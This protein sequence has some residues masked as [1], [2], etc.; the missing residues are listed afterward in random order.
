MLLSTTMLASAYAQNDSVASSD[1]INTV[2]VTGSYI[3]RGVDTPSPVTIMT[4][5][6]LD[7]TPRT[8]LGE[9]FHLDPAFSGSEVFTS[10]GTGLGSSG[11]ASVNLRG[12]GPRATLV[13][14]NGR[15]SV[16]NS[17]PTRDG[18][19]TFDINSLIPE[20]AIQRVEILKDGASAIYGSDAIAGV[21]NFITRDDFEGME[22]KANWS[23][24]DTAGQD[25]RLI[26]GIFGTGNDRSH[27]IVAVE[28]LDRDA[29][30]FVDFPDVYDWSVANGAYSNNLNPGSFR[31]IPGQTYNATVPAGPGAANRLVRDPLCGDSRLGPPERAGNPGFL[32]NSANNNQV[33]LVL[34][35]LGRGAISASKRVNAYA[36][37]T[38]EVS[39]LL[40]LGLEAGFSHLRLARAGG[41]GYA[42]PELLVPAS[43][44]GNTFG[45]DVMYRGSIFGPAIGNGNEQIAQVRNET[46]RL[47]FLADGQISEMGNWRWS[48]NFTWSR[49]ESLAQHPDTVVDRMAAA[50][51]GFGGANCDPTTGTAGVG[52]CSYFNPFA[53]Q[54]LASPGDPLYNDP[55]LVNYIRDTAYSISSSYMITYSAV[56]HGNLFDLPGG[57]AG[58]A[59]GYDYR[60]EQM[61]NDWDALTQGGGFAFASRSI[62]FNKSRDSNAAFFELSIPPI[63]HL[64]I[65]VAGRYE[66][67]GN[68]VNKF[69]PKGSLLWTPLDNLFVRA[70]AGKSFRAPD[71]LQSFGTN[72]GVTDSID[73]PGFVTNSVRAVTSPNPGLKPEQATS[74][75]A[76]V[77]WDIANNLTASLD[78]WRINFSDLT[79]QQDPNTVVAEYA[80]TGAHAN[81]LIFDGSGQLIQLNLVFDNFSSIH[82]RGFDFSLAWN[83]DI[84]SIGNISLSAR[85]SWTTKYTY[86]VRS[87][88]PV[89]DGLGHVNNNVTV[90]FPM[91]KLKANFVAGWQNDGH[92]AQATLRYISGM[93]NDRVAVDSPLQT[94]AAYYQL[95]LLYSYTFEI[96]G[97]PLTLRASVNNV[98]DERPPLLNGVQPAIPGVYDIRGRVFSLGLSKAF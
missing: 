67:Y 18:V 26:S 46:W 83:K 39:N 52:D 43:N 13:L 12:L 91:P 79:G 45:G 19:V 4:Q 95:D 27:I 32:G 64:E 25:E 11:S 89:V 50:L 66:D 92:Y 60:K 55:D 87:D 84:G 40:N 85:G 7:N 93:L 94:K 35:N 70:T 30:N 65:D 8:S 44:P 5:Q 63:E 3:P 16:Y 23:R 24:T 14:L 28:Y 47:A 88:L 2:T 56:V 48:S 51:Q 33:C 1:T 72:A 29:L 15:R 17:E 73:V 42:E 90:V 53:S 80:A 76:G 98:W 6:D 20:I 82:T 81:Q 75:T 38:Y 21:V 86:Q 41:Y 49:N 37:A 9:F 31:L 61:R 10:F 71:L 62:P 59:I 68:G 96:A 78:W 36:K 69:V 97:G 57:A 22:M 74:Y 77:T 58:I 54:Y 34:N